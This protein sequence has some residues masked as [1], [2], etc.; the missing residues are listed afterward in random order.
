M[1]AFDGA[2]DTIQTAVDFANDRGVYLETIPHPSISPFAKIRDFH[3]LSYFVNTTFVGKIFHS[4]N[5][6]LNEIKYETNNYSGTLSII[7]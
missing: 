1:I 5:N 7:Y 2:G 4:K 6:E 3:V